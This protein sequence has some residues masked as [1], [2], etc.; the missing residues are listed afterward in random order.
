MLHCIIAAARSGLKE[1]ISRSDGL[2]DTGLRGRRGRVRDAG[3]FMWCAWVL[4]VDGV[5]C[6]EF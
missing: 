1:Y 5:L 2:V 4:S 3:G 6:G